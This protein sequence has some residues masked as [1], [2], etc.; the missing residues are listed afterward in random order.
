MNIV[1]LL[2]PGSGITYNGDEIGMVDAQISYEDTVDPAG[3]NAGPDR[4][5]LFSRD[6]CRTPI[7]WDN[8]TSSGKYNVKL[9]S[10]AIFV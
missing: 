2:L 8:T 5:Q 10:N 9:V 4:Y 3:R 1:S 7:Q 6:P